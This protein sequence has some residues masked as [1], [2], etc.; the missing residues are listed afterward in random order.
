MRDIIFTGPVWWVAALWLL[1][2][3]LMQ[4][5]VAHYLM[6]RGAEFSFVLVLVVW[7]AM[8]ADARR[9]AVF[10]A[11]AGLLEDATGTLTGGSWTISTT[12]TALAANLV[13]RRFFADSVLVLTIVAFACTLLRRLLFWVLMAVTMSYPPGHARQHFH[14]ALYTAVMNAGLMAVVAA[15]RAR[16]EGRSLQ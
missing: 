14:E 15:L 13:A 2:A 9:A 5:E 16:A 11:I 8:H 7:Y 10:G 4:V 6:W 1:G 3:L 12:V